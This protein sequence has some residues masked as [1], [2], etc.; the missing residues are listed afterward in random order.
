[1]GAVYGHGCPVVG[2]RGHV[3]LQVGPLGLEPPLQPRHHRG[4]PGRGGVHQVAVAGQP[5]RHAVVHDHAV[6][7]EHEAV[8]AAAHAEAPPAVDVD[9]IQEFGGVRTLDIDLAEGG[10]VED[11]DAGAHG[12]ALPVHRVVHG[13]AGPGVVPGALPLA[14][15]LELRAGLDVPLVDGGLTDRVEE[16]AHV[17]AR[18]CAVGDR[19][20]GLAE[21][22]RAHLTERRAEGLGQH[23]N[24]VDGARLALVGAHAEG[25]VALDVLDGLVALSRGNEYVGGSNVGLEVDEALGGTHGRLP[26]GRDPLG[27]YAALFGVVRCRGWSRW[28]AVPEPGGS[29]GFGSCRPPLGEAALEIERAV[30]GAYRALGLGGDAGDE[31]SLVVVEA[32]LAAGLGVEAG[33]GVPSAGHGQQVAL[34]PPDAAVGRRSVVAHGSHGLHAP[35]AVHV[36]DGVSG[37]D[38]YPAPGDLGYERRAGIG[39]QVHYGADLHVGGCQGR[40][41]T[42]M[43]RRCW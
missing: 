28:L 4:R 7:A 40:G 38:L 34:H 41:R 16:R 42:G 20:V 19:G 14:D 43:R 3:D 22:G 35:A 25:G 15:V 6:L 27:A 32:Q 1:M 24:A 30:A 5:G 37:E 17:P 9:A 21:G 33:R 2:D 29:G 23:S 12:D 10:G 26:A 31:A 11:P 18:D 13:L 39:P 36:G 8:A